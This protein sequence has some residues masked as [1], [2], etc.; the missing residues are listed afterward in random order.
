MESEI[1]RALT[2]SIK[3]DESTS[4]QIVTHGISL[5]TTDVGRE[6]TSTAIFFSADFILEYI[7]LAAY[8][9]ALLAVAA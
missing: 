4:L 2:P 5:A 1:K 7:T 9:V 3:V 6:R 8:K